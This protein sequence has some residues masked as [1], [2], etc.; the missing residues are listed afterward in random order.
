[1]NNP[2]EPT[3]AQIDRGTDIGDQML[4]EVLDN[5]T[6]ESVERDADEVAVLF[7]LWVNLTRILTDAGWTP[8]ELSQEAG[9]HARQHVG[10]TLN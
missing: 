1:M 2:A 3:Q 9:Y 7:S 8:K 10:E 5:A 6:E 4:L